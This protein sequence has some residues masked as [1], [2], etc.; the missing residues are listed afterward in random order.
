MISTF[1][2]VLPVFALIFSGWGA[3]KLKILGEH[4]I[5]ELNRFVVYLAL[6]T[7][8]FDITANSHSSELWQPDFIAAYS[9]SSV[10][11]FSLPFLIQFRRNLPLADKAIGGLN[12]AY[13]NSGYM[14]IPLSIIA[15]GSDVL[16]TTIISMIVT[17]CVTFGV[18]IILIEIGTQKAANPLE[19]TWKVTRS[20]I[21]NPLMVAPTLGGIIAYL[22]WTLPAPIETFLKLL[23]GAAAPCALV[24]L[25]LFLAVPRKMQREDTAEIGFLV[26]TKLIIHPLVTW[27]VAVYFFNLPLL[28]AQNAALLAALP[29]GTGPFMLAEHYGRS[30]GITSNV[31]LYSTALSV[32][33]LSGLLAL[34]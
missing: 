2:V 33:T 12:A 29:A 3:F 30:P 14:G 9:I 17:L 16:P 11:A 15:F 21:R 1:I 25:G 32:I 6:P 19:F 34:M 5:T 7:L 26:F 31:I 13:P 4:A 27:I 10:I 8:L 24:A 23:G 28:I 18:A 22:G 20:L